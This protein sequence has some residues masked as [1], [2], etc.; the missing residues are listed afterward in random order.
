M[1]MTN[2]RISILDVVSSKLGGHK[3]ASEIR[4]AALSVVVLA[5][6]STPATAEMK[7]ENADGGSLIFYG[8]FDPAYLSFDDGVSTTSEIVDNSHSNSRVGI[9]IHDSPGENRWSFNF[10][11]A[12]GLRPSSAVSQVVT[13]DVIDWQLTD[14]RKVDLKLETE[15]Y[16]TFYLGQGSMATDGVAET[17]LSGTSLVTY[18]SIADTAGFFQFRTAAGALSGQRIAGAFLNYDGVRL[19]RVRYDTP[20]FEGLS[21]STSF[22]K[23]ILSKIA[24]LYSGDVALRYHREVEDVVVKGAIGYSHTNN[25][26]LGQI[27]NNTMGSFALLHSSGFNFQIAAGHQQRAGYYG[28]GKLGYKNKW[29][30]VGTTAIS[31]DIYDGRDMTSPGS[32]SKTVG[33]GLVQSFDDAKIDAYLGYRRYDLSETATL[34]RDAS[35]LMLGAR[36]KF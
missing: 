31:I 11:T 13:P 35:S 29:F 21:V 4:K 33:L 6:L 23:N 1:K 17:D 32:R 5:G 24:D 3:L 28:Y 16:G 19:G 26:V 27:R 10:E 2:N 7:L 34:Y 36:W 9:W 18:S 14:I 15:Q 25:R 30:S 22:G 8:Q 12:L 20:A